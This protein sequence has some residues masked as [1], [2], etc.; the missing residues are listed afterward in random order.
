MA[1]L[2]NRTLLLSLKNSNKA[3]FNVKDYEKKIKEYRMHK[4]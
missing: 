2:N 1:Y 3:Y 4:K